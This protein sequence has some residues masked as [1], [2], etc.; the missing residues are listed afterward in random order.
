MKN[1]TVSSSR[2]KSPRSP[3]WGSKVPQLGGCEYFERCGIESWA[4]EKLLLFLIRSDCLKIGETEISVCW[5]RWPNCHDQPHPLSPILMQF[6]KPFWDGNEGFS[7]TPASGISS[8][9]SY[10]YVIYII[11]CQVKSHG[12]VFPFFAHG[13][14]LF[15]SFLTPILSRHRKPNSLLHLN[16]VP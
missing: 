8:V 16:H 14:S 9:S 4:V 11:E 12:T 13:M 6:V 1:A 3:C 7:L 10:P 2:V 5:P 15:D